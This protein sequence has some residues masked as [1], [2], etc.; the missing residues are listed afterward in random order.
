MAKLFKEIST[1]ISATFGAATAAVTGV[2]NII[3]T[4]ADSSAD[5]IK[6]TMKIDPDIA[7]TGSE[8]T[9]DILAEAKADNKINAALRSF[10]LSAFEEA[11]EDATTQQKLKAK[12]Q[13]D[14]MDRL[15][16]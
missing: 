15:F 3:T 5:S 14:I 16:D 8:Y 9:E 7:T 11:M 6:P 12:A 1:S 4:I 13:L 10:K 2:S